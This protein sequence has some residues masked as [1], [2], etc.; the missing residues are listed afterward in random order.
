[1][2]RTP[3]RRKKSVSAASRTLKV[4][5]KDGWI[6]ALAEKWNPFVGIRQDLFGFMDILALKPGH[7]IRAINATTASEIGRH[8]EKYRENAALRYWLKS[9]GQPHFE[10]WAWRRLKSTEEGK[11][12]EW[13]PRVFA[14]EATP[15]FSA[16]ERNGTDP[17]GWGDAG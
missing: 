12:V 14:F 15:A 4:L 7:R 10:L 8:I 9:I 13:R 3:T 2:D 17:Q 5:K 1:M 16:T 6:C 11:R